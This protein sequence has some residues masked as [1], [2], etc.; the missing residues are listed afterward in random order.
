MT[1]QRQAAYLDAYDLFEAVQTERHV[2]AAAALPRARDAAEQLQWHDVGFVLA[3]AQVVHSMNRSTNP[4]GVAAAA[5]ALVLRA[6]PLDAPA[7]LAVALG[8][9]AIIRSATGDTSALLADAGRAVALLD[10]RDQP[11]LDR[12]TGYVVAAGAFNTLGLWELVDELYTLAADLEPQCEVPVQAAA[13]A[14]NRIITRLEWAMSLL[15]LGDEEGAQHRLEEAAAAV[16]AARTCEHLPPLWQRD[17]EA[18]DLIVRLLRGESES[19]LRP[20]LASNREA[21]VAGEDVE[22]LPLLDAAH[23]LALWRGGDVAAAAAAAESTP[24]A[25]CGVRSFPLWVRAQILAGGQPSAAVRA[26]R[27]H[28]Q[29]VSRLRWES[30]QAVVAAARAQITAERHQ[31]ERDQLS[32][33]VNTDPLTGLSNRRPFDAWLHRARSTPQMPAALLLADVDDFK[34]INDTFGHDTGDQVLRRFGELLLACVRPG[35]LAVRHGGDEFAVLL[36]GEHLTEWVARRRAEEL[37]AVLAREPWSMLS[38]GLRVTAS[39]GLAVTIPSPG[40]DVPTGLAP[41]DLYRAADAALYAG[42]RAGTGLHVVTIDPV[43]GDVVR[44]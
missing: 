1:A 41:V 6:E 37:S 16:A 44:C 24:S 23:A 43:A 14:V 22:A 15:E 20:R 9:R 32:R 40:P 12:C 10:D 33:A 29:M 36:Q 8:I 11:A 28:N 21:L 38:R 5:D 42:K 17:V 31:G 7:L 35:D 4:D 19:V 25:S 18:G 34:Q 30:R 26:Q 2:A 3:A 39:I 13:I 27:D